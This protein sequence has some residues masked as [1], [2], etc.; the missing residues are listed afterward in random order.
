M[1]IY[2]VDDHA[3]LLDGISQLLSDDPD[4]HISG[5]AA[6][7]EA[8]LTF[9]ENHT[10]DLLITDYSLPGID[11]MELIR[12]VKKI[13][14]S[15]KIIVLSMHDEAVLVNSILKS[16][17][18]GYVLK[19]DSHN[20]LLS[21]IKAVQNNQIYISQ[22]LQSVIV[23]GLNE[24]AK[25]PLLTNRE[26]EILVLIAQEY[27]NKQIASKL[28]IS[29]RT[30]ETHRKNLFRKTGVSSVVGLVNYGYKH[31]LI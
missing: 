6:S 13:M 20:E 26:R 30:V 12:L 28:L 14:P 7:A 11:G 27:T 8:A 5:R 29:E 18:H 16:G 17:V 2:L 23:S 31:Q 22:D 25:Q 3:I 21:A 19:K 4:I 15:I 9:L 1:N 10:V 24:T